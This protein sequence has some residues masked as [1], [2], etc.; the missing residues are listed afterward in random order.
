LASTN[1]QIEEIRRRMAQIRMELH[2][3]M[4]GVVAGTDA[5]TDWRY[6][7]R[8]YPW[9]SLGAAALVGYLVIPRRRRSVTEV[10]RKA[11]EA[12]TEKVQQA[13]ETAR[14]K[15][16]AKAEGPAEKETRKKGML[17]LALGFLAPV[18]S[19]AVQGYAAQYVENLIAQQGM[20]MGP[21]PQPAAP[22]GGQPTPPWRA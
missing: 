1:E 18:V 11:A 16:K 20:T 12:A 9:A 8:L 7:V 2:Q 10:A 4:Q 22:S 13:V 5:A 15:T 21:Q 14:P 19:R 3:D 17:G 6:Y